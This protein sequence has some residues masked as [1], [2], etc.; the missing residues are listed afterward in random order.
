MLL[1][2]LVFLA[3]LVSLVMIPIA[4]I[5]P[6]KFDRIFRPKATR[7]VAGLT[8]VS[9]SLILL[10]VCIVVV[11]ATSDSKTEKRA[12]RKQ[13]Q[14]GSSPTTAPTPSIKTADTNST[15]TENV[16]YHPP[17]MNI[18]G[19]PGLNKVLINATIGTN[20]SGI[21]FTNNENQK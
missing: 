16:D 4:F 7:M 9:L 20:E 1:F 10:V 15:D 18:S 6:S 12:N 8:M 14:A 11:P 2:A 13:I 21:I 3:F 5:F 17:A 19:Y